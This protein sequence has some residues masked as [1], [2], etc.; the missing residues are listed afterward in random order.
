MTT[1]LKFFFRIG[2]PKCPPA[3]ALVT[4]LMGQGYAVE[5]YC[6]DTAD[7]LSEGA[8]NSVMATPTLI[9]FEGKAEQE[10]EIKRWAGEMPSREVL[11]REIGRN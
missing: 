10:E 6:M 7:G 5:M 9:L 4:L 1:R 11:Q 3:H 8:L 2:C